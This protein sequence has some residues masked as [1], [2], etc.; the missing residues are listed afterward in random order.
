MSFEFLNQLPAPAD[1][2][3]EASCRAASEL[4]KHR[5]LMISD[6][7]TGK[8]S[9]VLRI[10]TCSADNE[11]FFWHRFFRLKAFAVLTKGRAFSWQEDFLPKKRLLG[12]RGFWGGVGLWTSRLGGCDGL[13][14]GANVSQKRYKNSNILFIF[15]LGSSPTNGL[16]IT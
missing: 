7:I 13:V 5:D 6:V 9:R 15:G 16:L 2:S 14:C 12:A 8:D 11:D 3:D 1:I 10:G 4:K